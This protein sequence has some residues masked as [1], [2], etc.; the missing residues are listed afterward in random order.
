MAVSNRY[1]FPVAFCAIPIVIFFAAVFTM[2]VNVP[3]QDDFD[4][5]LE[6]V[7]LL[8]TGQHS[9][10]EFWNIIYT[11]DDERRIVVDRLIA[12]S[13][14]KLTGELNLKAMVIGGALNLLVLLIVLYR[15]FKDTQ[16]LWIFFLPIPWLLFNV[17]FYETV[18][19]AMIPFQHLA[20]FI[21]AILTIWLL[22]RDST[23]YF[24]AAVVTAVLTIYADVSG[25]FILPAGALVLAARQNWRFLGIW[26]IVIGIIVWYYFS[27]LVIPEYRPKFSDNFSNP[28]LLVS[29]LITLF[30]IWSDPGPTFPIIL[31]EGVSF[32][33]GIAA[34]F[35]TLT[36]LIRTV[37]P[38]L[39]HRMPLNKNDAFLWGSTCF[40]AIVLA[41]LASG[42]ASEGLEAIFNPRYRHMYVIW[43]IFVYLLAIRYYPGLFRSGMVKAGLLAG[44]VLFCLNAYIMY[45]GGLD[46]YRKTFLSDAYQWYY[47]R[48]LPSSPIYL[49]LRE[50]VDEIYEGVYR[51]KIYVPEKYPFAQLPAAPVK[52]EVE[53]D[54]IRHEG[55]VEVTVK[56]GG[57]KMA[58]NDGAYVIF[59]AADGET[60]ILPAHHTQRPLH[61]LLIDRSYYY[62]EAR[63]DPYVNGYF[64]AAE[65]D[66][67]VG[68]IE[69]K[70]QYRLL[71]GKQLRL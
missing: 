30:G 15:W 22:S 45:W 31:R 40:T 57:R 26:L 39:K 34:L 3:F 59:R 58:K 5:L 67:E 64:K 48:S 41:V 20:V 46:K 2:S 21:W 7:L 17:Q 61:R 4:G 55:S 37:R 13:I 33:V 47:N 9:W 28:F 29:V 65:F 8:Q 56:G 43:M 1:F 52:G 38:L 62:P 53:I 14:F 25:N 70:N 44:S 16:T 24:G 71:T 51:E 19:W 23:A 42:R 63:I 68:V 6:P 18:F 36:V 32:L 66:I 10:G 60:H 35:F 11:Q 49:A 27:G 69:G 54:L 12:Y 50:R